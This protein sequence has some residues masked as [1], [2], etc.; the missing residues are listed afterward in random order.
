MQSGNMVK[1]LFSQM[2][3]K[4]HLQHQPYI[5]RILVLG[6]GGGSVVELLNKTYPE[7]EITAIEIDPMM[8]QAGRKYLQL[9]KSRRLKIIFADVFKLPRSKIKYDLVIVDLFRG[10]E[11]PAQLGEPSFLR[12]LK[13]L[14][15][16]QGCIVF[17]RLYFQKHIFEANQ[18]L[19]KLEGIFQ[20]VDTTKVYFN[21]F[22]KAC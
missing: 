10:E 14:T 1:Q 4:F 13:S 9:G 12:Y 8:V 5:K 20:H 17:N 11:T 7:A 2:L 3:K 16:E 21:L 6:L 15:T 19:N 22:I 18:F